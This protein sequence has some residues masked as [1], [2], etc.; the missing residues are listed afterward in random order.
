[1]TKRSQDMRILALM[2]GTQLFGSERGNIEGYKA[3]RKSGAK[4]IVA[5]SNREPG[6]G[7]VGKVLREEN[8][9]TI[10][11][12]Y[13]GKFD[14][15]QMRTIKSDRKR[16]LKRLWT[17]SILLH[18]AI[19]EHRITHVTTGNCLAF[20]FCGIALTVNRVPLIYRMGDA[21]ETESK[22][23]LFIWHWMVRRA[24]TIVAISEFIKAKAIEH[25]PRSRK[26]I[27]VI[28]NRPIQRQGSASQELLEKLEKEKLPLQLVYVGQ[29]TSQKGI[30]VLVDA[31]IRL[32]DSRIGCW[33]V[34]GGKYTA[35]FEATL[36]KN[37]RD[38]QS[39]TTI[40]F[41][42]FQSDVRPFYVA[43]DWHIAPSLY[44]EP[45]GNIVQEAKAC[46][47]PSIVSPY[48]GLPELITP[49]ING[50]ILKTVSTEAIIQTIQDIA[51]H[52]AL[53]DSYGERAFESIK[54][55]LDD[56]TF[57]ARWR[58]I[59]ARFNRELT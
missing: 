26:K 54:G 16:Q 56:S 23:Q 28:L 21:P 42:G 37:V 53:H 43:A 55:H 58:M 41:F 32:D 4:L 19:K 30:S 50:K 13:G 17:N 52:E 33:I 46:K 47:T 57:D 24:T 14:K 40:K 45:L 20:L 2:P 6:G 44:E 39:K 59:L 8:F 12:P 15:H 1:M 10:A 9:Q 38:S 34:G 35:N 49:N 48:G 25:S 18:R 11:F 51:D 5:I 7:E 3:M 31:L 22:F 29:M 36:K 27:F